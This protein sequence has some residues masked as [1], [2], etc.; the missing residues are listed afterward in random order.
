MGLLGWAGAE[1][2]GADARMRD[3]ELRLR[4]RRRLA[5]DWF[6]PM[7]GGFRDFP[8]ARSLLPRNR[9]DHLLLPNRDIG[10]D[11]MPADC[12]RY[13]WRPRP[14]RWP[15]VREFHWAGPHGRS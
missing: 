9:L 6:F 1:R 12:P 7:C 4:R 10:P 8:A 2:S 11:P 5:D 14:I 13:P 15:W 3:R